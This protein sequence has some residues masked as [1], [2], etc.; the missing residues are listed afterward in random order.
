MH[1]SCFHGQSVP[2]GRRFLPADKAIFR[3]NPDGLQGK[4][5]QDASKKAVQA[6]CNACKNDGVQWL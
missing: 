3:S 1:R 2:D 5:T 4:A 6:A